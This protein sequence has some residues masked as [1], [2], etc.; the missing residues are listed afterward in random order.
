M[1]MCAYKLF[2]LTGIPAIII[3]GLF[4]SP[5]EKYLKFSQS[6]F[7]VYLSHVFILPITGALL[8]FLGDNYYVLGGAYLVRPFVVGFICSVLFFAL[9]QVAPGFLK[10]LNGGR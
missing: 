9:K 2:I 5:T 1:Y 3:G 8:V 6:S 7:F 10:V 4:I